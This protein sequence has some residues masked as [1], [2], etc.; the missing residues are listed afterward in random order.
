MSSSKALFRMDPGSGLFFNKSAETLMKVNAITAVVFLLIGGILATLVTA[1]RMPTLH[2]LPTAQFYQALT[3]H[4]IDMLII[5]IIFFEMAVLYFA[6]T[7]LLRVRIAAP[8]WGWV[9]YILMLVG[10][11]MTNYAILQGNSSVM[12]TS[13]VPM[14]AEPLFY[15]GLILFAVGALIGCFIFF[16]TLVIAKEERTYEGSVPLIVYGATVAAIIAVFTI[17]SGA[18]ILIPTFLWSVGLVSHIDPLMYRVIWWALGH[19][20]QQINVAAHITIWYMVAGL[21]FGAKPMS[22]KVSRTAFLLYILFLQLASAH[23]ILVDPGV[24]STWKVFNTSYAM[25]LAVLAS[26]IHGLTVP[27]SIEVAQRMKGLNN[28]LFTWLQ[29]APWG[30]PVFSSMF[31]SLIGFGFIGGI[32]GVVMGVEQIN[33]I[34]HNT[35]YVPGHFHATVVLGTTMAFMSATYFLLPT[36]F[37]RE[38]FMFKLAKLQPYLFGLG[39]AGFSVFM[40]GAGTM[41]VAR[42]HWDMAFTGAPY[43]FEYPAIAYTLMGLTGIF[44][45]MAIIG[46]ALFCVIAVGTLLFGKK[47]DSKVGFMGF[48]GADSYTTDRPPLLERAPADTVSHKDIGIGG[49]VAPGTFIMALVFLATFV[50]YYFV[51]WKYLSSVWGLS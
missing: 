4:G 28:G 22:E 5:F 1:T 24:S 29:K 36:L 27:G 19:S 8:R 2:T 13:Y 50:L 31:I 46:G 40:M 34:I 18:I 33:L 42:R 35:I 25:Y 38:I 45:A 39:M 23:H 37:G 10:A 20:S 9:Q 21:L 16:G 51:N 48:R 11:V 26:M 14:P 12:M 17:A 30:N 7:A 32:S 15:L 47:V 6:S 49:F 43:A 3:A 41:G 44:A